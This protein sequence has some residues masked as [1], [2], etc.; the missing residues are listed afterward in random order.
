MNI[1][2]IYV[3]L[4]LASPSLLSLYLPPHSGQKVTR[5]GHHPQNLCYVTA[6]SRGA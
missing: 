4:S 1:C 5:M 6:L 2:G 3:L